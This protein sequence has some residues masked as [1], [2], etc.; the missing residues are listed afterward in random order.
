MKEDFGKLEL[1]DGV[2]FAAAGGADL[3]NFKGYHNQER[4]AAKKERDKRQTDP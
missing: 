4:E 2:D 3:N 1:G